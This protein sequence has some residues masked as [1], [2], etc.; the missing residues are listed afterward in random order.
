MEEF[1]PDYCG[2][3]TEHS[4]HAVAVLLCME[5]WK[6]RLQSRKRNP[7]GLSCLPFFWGL[8]QFEYNPFLIIWQ[9]LDFSM[10]G[11]IHVSN[12]FFLYLCLNLCMDSCQELCTFLLICYL[13]Y[14]TWIF[15]SPAKGLGFCMGHVISS[16][17][18]Q[19]SIIRTS[20]NRQQLWTTEC[21][22]LAVQ[23]CH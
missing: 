11:Y 1:W 3:P 19:A 7:A 8:L 18:S 20:W 23:S 9:P 21:H 15:K 5:Q 12:I 13:Q 10:Y 16:L 17:S 22:V 4:Q 6:N 2:I 14:F